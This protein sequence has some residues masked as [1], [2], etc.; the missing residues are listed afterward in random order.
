MSS[1]LWGWS[2]T[3]KGLLLSPS[4]RLLPVVP[5]AMTPQS[6]LSNTPARQLQAS[7][8]LTFSTVL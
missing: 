6:W 7:C 5:D 3:N 2:H 4:A 1:V 8:V